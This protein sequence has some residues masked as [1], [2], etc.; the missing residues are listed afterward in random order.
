MKEFR[1]LGA[2]AEHLITRQAATAVVM[3]LYLNVRA[4]EVANVLLAQGPVFATHSSTRSVGRSISPYWL[5]LPLLA[6]I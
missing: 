3:F 1:S 4:A 2:F 5:C 6:S